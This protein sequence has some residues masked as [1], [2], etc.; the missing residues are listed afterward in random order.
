M[1]HL[2]AKKPSPI[3]TAAVVKPC[4]A[5]ELVIMIINN[6]ILYPINGKVSVDKRVM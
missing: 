6:H 4:T 1:N 3:A 2:S 5:E